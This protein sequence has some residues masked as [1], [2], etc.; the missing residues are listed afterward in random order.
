MS[1]RQAIHRLLI[2][3]LFMAAVL[4]GR[5]ACAGDTDSHL[6][7]PCAGALFQ[8]SAFAHGYIHGYE[9]GFHWGNL[10]F[11]TGRTDAHP[12]ES[13]AAKASYERT[14][15]SRIKFKAG[16]HRG[17][18]AGY[19]DGAKGR[20]FRGT[21]ALTEAARDLPTV[22]AEP[23]QS[24]AF[25]LGLNDGYDLGRVRG[26]NASRDDEEYDATTD[27]CSAGSKARAS[28]PP[29]DCSGF[30]RGY[31]IGYS[32]GYLGTSARGAAPTTQA[33]K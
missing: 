23:K 28:L 25:D 8:R 12:R 21:Q 31:L 20:E 5:A 10:D 9:E 24:A 13:R 6:A 30:Q 32:D 18:V 4:S 19:H 14:F 2:A 27:L 1:Q 15:G 33:K 16:Y 29:L 17:F 11:Q 22:S 7:Q 26:A 3:S